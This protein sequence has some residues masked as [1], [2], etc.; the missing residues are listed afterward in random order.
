MARP[1]GSGNVL[2][3]ECKR[4]ILSVY[5]ALGGAEAML[6]WARRNPDKY[7]DILVRVLPREIDL[8]VKV[9]PEARVYPLGLPH[10]E[11]IDNEQVRLPIASKTMDSI[12]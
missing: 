6:T 11:T 12:H 4:S 9:S 5:E 8:D 3:Y 2:S 10:V 7:Y 1:K